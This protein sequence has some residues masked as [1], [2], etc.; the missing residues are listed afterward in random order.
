M[1]KWKNPRIRKESASG[2][3]VDGVLAMIWLEKFSKAMRMK[4]HNYAI[5]LP[6]TEAAIAR[7]VEVEVG[8]GTDEIRTMETTS[9][10]E[11]GLGQT[12]GRGTVRHARMSKRSDG[13]GSTD[14]AQESGGDSGQEVEAMFE[15]ITTMDAGSTENVDQETATGRGH[16]SETVENTEARKAERYG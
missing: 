14:H 1:E 16:R 4:G 15:I 6:M 7:E 11:G 12:A 5:G 3:T 13:I 8:T 10:E 9:T 2:L